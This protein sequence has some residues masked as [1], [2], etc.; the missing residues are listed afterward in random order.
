MSRNFVFYYSMNDEIGSG[1]FSK[2]YEPLEQ[3]FDLYEDA[4]FEV[5]LREY[6][7]NGGGIRKSSSRIEKSFALDCFLHDMK[8][9]GSDVFRYFYPMYRSWLLQHGRV[10]EYLDAYEYDND[11]CLDKECWV[12]TCAKIIELIGAYDAGNYYGD[13]HVKLIGY[14]SER[15]MQTRFWVPEDELAEHIGNVEFLKSG[16]A[17]P[18]SYRL[19]QLSGRIVFEEFLPVFYHDLLHAPDPGDPQTRGLKG[20]YF[21]KA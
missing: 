12:H 16:S 10:M 8:N 19:A 4:E 5:E 17:G 13:D 7:L 21:N 18:Y 6:Y 3:L 1:C 15:G 2:N 14:Y 11:Y 20:Y 9:S